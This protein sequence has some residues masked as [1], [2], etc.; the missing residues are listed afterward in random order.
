MGITFASLSHAA[1]SAMPSTASSTSHPNLPL[2]H[3]HQALAAVLGFNTH[4]ALKAAVQSGE[5]PPAY[6]EANCILLDLPR[7]MRR[8]YELGH[9]TRADAFAAAV[10]E[11][12]D[13]LLPVA[14]LC[15]S[16]SDLG[17]EFHQQVADAIES[18]DSYSSALASTNAFGGYFDLSFHEAAP[19]DEARGQ[20]VL[21]AEGTSSLEQDLDR[22]FSG[23]VID[24]SA[25]VVF[26][27]LGRRVLGEMSID[28]TGASVQD[29]GPDPDEEPDDFES[30]APLAAEGGRNV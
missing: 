25:H 29:W 12:F 30:P 16:V 18:D 9:A 17:D 26:E 10:R 22:V 2:G 20:W 15:E 4:A 14:K 27:K 28:V 23:D 13:T 19:I 6:D 7:L 3:V 24:V 21:V 5:E 1:Q 11:A 8:I